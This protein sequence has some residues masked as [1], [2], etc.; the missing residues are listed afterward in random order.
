VNF[1]D[2]AILGVFRRLIRYLVATWRPRMFLHWRRVARFFAEAVCKARDLAWL[3]RVRSPS[4]ARTMFSRLL[5]AINTTLVF[6]KYAV[7]TVGRG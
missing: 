3:N 2:G 1:L 5:E 6:P 7:L 4:R